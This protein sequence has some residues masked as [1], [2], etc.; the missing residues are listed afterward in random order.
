MENDILTLDKLNHSLF[1][2]GEG[3]GEGISIISNLKNKEESEEY[4]RLLKTQNLEIPNLE[5]Y[6]QD[7]FLQK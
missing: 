7:N 5:N 1:V 6:S 3:E 4:N 2:F